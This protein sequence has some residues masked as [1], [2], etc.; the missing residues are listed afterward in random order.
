MGDARNSNNTT[1]CGT[2]G[3]KH[4][5]AKTRQGREKE[6]CGADAILNRVVREGPALMAKYKSRGGES[7]LCRYQEDWLSPSTA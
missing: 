6:S 7:E 4:Y 2:D 5:G 1:G 3:G